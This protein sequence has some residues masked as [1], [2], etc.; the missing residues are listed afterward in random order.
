MN[1]VTALHR[2]STVQ[3]WAGD[4]PAARR[5]GALALAAVATAAGTLLW[6]GT[7]QRR[8]QRERTPNREA[9]DLHGAAA[10][11]CASVLAD[12]AVEH[13]RAR[14]ENPGMW[15]PLLTSALG[16]AAG[17]DGAARGRLPRGLRRGVYGLAC[18]VGVAGL[19]F[20][21]YNVARRPGGFG[22]LNLFYAAPLG[23]PAALALGGALGLA[24]EQLAQRPHRRRWRGL[25]VGRLLCGLVSFGLAGTVGEAA[26]LHYRGSFHNPLMWLPVTVPPV[27]S[28]LTA[29]AAL[30]TNPRRDPWLTRAWLRLTALLGLGGVG[31]HAYGVSRAMGGWRNWQQNLLDGPPLPAPPSFT[32]LAVA[33][34]A[35]LRLRE[36]DDD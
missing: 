31:L 28:A 29:Q 18:G 32:A 2:V 10:G 23:A 4:P 25:P 7:R 22:W 27:A 24:G 15:A 1:V 17:L 20:H 6:Q 14:F 11:L 16:I 33:G 3:G 36:H 12:S 35:A 8:L 19:G 9:R 13:Y 26:L 21:A 34:L 5:T 30:A